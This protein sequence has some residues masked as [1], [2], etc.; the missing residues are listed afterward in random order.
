MG[1]PFTPEMLSWDSGPVDEWAKWGGYH[2][3]AE[4]STGFKKEAPASSNEAAKPKAKVAE[5][6]QS[7]V[8]ACNPHYQYLLSKATIRAP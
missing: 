7:A 2:N 5:H 6:L 4:N 8:D 1:I 3:A